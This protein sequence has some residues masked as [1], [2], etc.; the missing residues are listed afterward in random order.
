MNAEMVM[1]N[2]KNLDAAE[3]ALICKMA[4]VDAGVR[5]TAKDMLEHL[6]GY[7][8]KLQSAALKAIDEVSAKDAALYSEAQS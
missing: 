1:I 5:Y 2:L 4:H 3:L 7:S 8:G 6:V